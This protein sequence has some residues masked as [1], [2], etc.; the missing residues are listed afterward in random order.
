MGEGEAEGR[1]QEVLT[2]FYKTVRE[3]LTEKLIC[4]EKNQRRL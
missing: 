2:L 4:R 1:I 3:Y